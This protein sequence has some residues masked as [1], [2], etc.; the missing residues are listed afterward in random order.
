MKYDIIIHKYLLCVFMATV[1]IPNDMINDFLILKFF[2][3]DH[4][5]ISMPNIFVLNHVMEHLNN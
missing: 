5:L 3:S 2:F 4:T 1:N